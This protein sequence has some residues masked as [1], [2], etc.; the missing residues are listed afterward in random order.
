M[1]LTTNLAWPASQR[2]CSLR[3]SPTSSITAKAE[4]EALHSRGPLTVKLL[5]SERKASA[6]TSQLERVPPSG[7][8]AEAAPRASGPTS[9]GANV[10][11]S[12]TLQSLSRTRRRGS[13]LATTSQLGS[14]LWRRL[15]LAAS[16]TCVRVA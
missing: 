16:K 11:P 5:R 15:K 2:D 14:A 13:M 7:I 10:A 4:E 8:K 3:A 12:S 1:R 6:P 9:Q